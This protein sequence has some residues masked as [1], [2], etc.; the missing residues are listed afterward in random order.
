M[1]AIEIVR[2]LSMVEWRSS[3]GRISELP[4][5][6]CVMRRV[7]RVWSFEQRLVL[8]TAPYNDHCDPRLECHG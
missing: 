2:Q 8:R 3:P 5:L 1:E 4:E 6:A 7:I